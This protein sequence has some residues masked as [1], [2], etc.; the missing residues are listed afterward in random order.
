MEVDLNTTHASSAVFRRTRNNDGLAAT[1][2][3][4]DGSRSLM[5]AKRWERSPKNLYGIIA[6]V[7]IVVFFDGP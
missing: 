2:E 3:F 4:E 7:R 6:G 5:T 1:K